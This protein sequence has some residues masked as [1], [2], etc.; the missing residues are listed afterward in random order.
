M[1]LASI[2]LFDG[3]FIE[4][5]SVGRKKENMLPQICYLL[6]VALGIGIALSEHGKPKEG[7]HN[8]L[9]HLIGVS[10]G[11]AI[12]YWGGFFDPLFTR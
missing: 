3:A 12:L 8:F 6:L 10:V 7:K 11:L 5:R 4:A 1:R 9:T 2:E